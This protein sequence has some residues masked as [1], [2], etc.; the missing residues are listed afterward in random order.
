MKQ[1][2][3][4]QTK[5]VSFKGELKDVELLLIELEK[6]KKNNPRLF[7]NCTIIIDVIS[8]IIL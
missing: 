7:K 5:Q 4:K 6:I 3:I 8:T 2:K 1:T